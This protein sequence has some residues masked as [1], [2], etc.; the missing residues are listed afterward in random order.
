VI[1]FDRWCWPL[2]DPHTLI[3]LGGLAEHDYGPGVP[4]VL[5]LEYS[6]ADFAAM[7]VFARRASPAGS[8][9]V[10]TGGDLARSARWDQVL[11]LVGI[12][13]EAVVACRD[14]LGCWGWLKAYRDGAEPPF[15]ERDLEL[16]AEVGPCLGAA[17]RRSLVLDGRRGDAPTSPSG[18]L[19]L[20]ADLR[21]VS[22]T[23]AARAWVDALPAAELYAAFGMLPAMVYP[24]ATIARSGNGSCALER[25]VDGRW[26][27]IE[28]ARLQGASDGAIAVTFRDATTGEAFDRLS[29]IYGFTRRE[30]EV[31]AALLAGLDTR[32]MTTRLYISPHTV[33]DHLKSVF[34][35]ARVHSRRELLARFSGW[36]GAPVQPD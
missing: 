24:I 22:W 19:L 12:G 36:N 26:V 10:E 30:R 15:A 8:L 33:Q 23:A 31:V 29:R 18:V 35:K 27:M 7:N 34:E 3:P 4:R 6:G 13:D 9:S 20:D 5:E 1:G 25:T 28:A 21:P 16:L 14:G 11:R 32:A 2:A 17:L